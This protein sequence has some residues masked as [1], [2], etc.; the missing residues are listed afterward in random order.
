MLSSRDAIANASSKDMCQS[1]NG[2]KVITSFWAV[3]VNDSQ[4]D[5]VPRQTHAANL[6]VKIR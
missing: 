3:N 2:L 6:I 5:N 4:Q 1:P